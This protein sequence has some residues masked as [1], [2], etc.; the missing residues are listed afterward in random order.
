MDVAS[1]LPGRRRRKVL[2]S[3]VSAALVAG[4]F[5]G[6]LPQMADF[7]EVWAAIVDMTW[8]EVGTLGLAAAWNILTYLLVMIAVLPG[9]TLM[10]AFVVGQSS[11]A[12]AVTMPAGSALGI[13][14]T[15]AMYSSWG[16]DGSEIGLAA[17]LSGLWNTLV[18]LAL[19]VI[20]LAALALTG[21][22]SRPL[23]SGP[24]VGALALV[25]AVGVFALMLRSSRFAAAAGARAGAA[26]SRLRRLARRA[27]VRGWDEGAVRFRESTIG[28]LRDR[29]LHLTLAT[30][31]SH[32]SL[33]LVLLLALRHVGVGA[34]QVTWVEALAAFALVRLVTAL[35]V[36]PGGL[37]VV[38]LGLVAALVFAGGAESPVVAAVLV[39]RFLTLVVQV[40]LG[41]GSYV[42]WSSRNRRLERQAAV[43]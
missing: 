15:Y 3:V 30:L 41:A 17:V 20:A 8:L 23:I 1:P 26:V 38:E 12:V 18:K 25:A 11:T 10:Q 2:R 32:L 35:P 43:P 14:V 19:P 28:L 13:G 39:F 7:S 4:I 34:A 27:P 37:G 29:W 33:Y 40:P 6:V 24:V 9:L 31:M 22:V 21:D 42:W 36:T 5:L 16:R